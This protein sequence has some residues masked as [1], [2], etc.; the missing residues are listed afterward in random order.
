MSDGVKSVSEQVAPLPAGRALVARIRCLSDNIVTLIHDPATGATAT[1]DV[2]D[3]AAV[4]ALA[5]SLGWRITDI[6]V[7]HR[8]SDH[9]QGVPSLRQTTG[10]RLVAPALAADALPGADLV[11]AG[12]ER[13]T[14]GSLGVEVIAT[15]GHCAD[16]V[17]FHVPDALSV[18]CGDTLFKL[19]CGRV[20]DS[21]PETLWVSL[22]RLMALPAETLVH[23]GHDYTLGNARFAAAVEPDSGPARERLVQ[24]EADAAAGRLTTLTTIGWERKA[25]PFLRADEP[26]IAAAAGTPQ[27]GPAETFAALR[28]WKNRF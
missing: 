27:G 8:H 21:T 7:T 28:A 20:F 16:H 17:S 5:G 3:A 24:A 6:L 22:Q 26:A 23:C 13:F 18:A 14:L 25:N 19:G 12:G 4:S 9:I 2:P 11:V 1:I 15:P 10:A